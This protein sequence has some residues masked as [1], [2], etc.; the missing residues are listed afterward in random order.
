MMSKLAEFSFQNEEKVNTVQ[1]SHVKYI[2]VRNLKLSDEY[3]SINLMLFANVKELHLTNN[4]FTFLPKCV[5]KCHF[6][7]KLVLDDC[8]DLQEI[9]GIPSCLRM[10]SA[11]NCMSLT[12]SC[13]SKLL[14]QVMIYFVFICN[15]FDILDIVNLTLLIYD[16]QE[17][18]E[19]GNTWF[20]L[21]R[22]PNIP[23]WFD[24]K[25]E[26]GLSISFWF[27]SKFPPIA[28]C[29][30]SPVTWDSSR[31]RSVRVII[32]GN[33]FFY[34]D[35]LKMGTKSPP[36]TYHLHLFHMKMENF[37]DTM[38]KALLENSWNH[39]DVDF[40]LPFQKSGIHVL[41]E[42]SSMKDIRFT[43]PEN[44][45]NIVFTQDEVSILLYDVNFFRNFTIDFLCIRQFTIIDF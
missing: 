18:H 29:L 44:D 22:V 19:A 34:T 42:K 2:C 31:R 5:E 16:Q 6:L 8:K 1:S 17:L 32:N 43:N 25:Y 38:D 28:L 15:V 36:K 12:S 11:L 13:K 3:L 9:K 21:P 7:W 40:G 23:E 35:G 10:L 20:R 27:R 30:V 14:N 4:Q 37:N 24:R 41:K 45:A 33:T 39:A 26:A